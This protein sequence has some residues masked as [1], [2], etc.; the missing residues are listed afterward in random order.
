LNRKH[1]QLATAR[2]TAQALDTWQHWATGHNTT[3]ATLINTA[4]HLAARGGRHA[5]LAAPLT[6]WIHEHDIVPRPSITP[7]PA[8]EHHS[9]RRPSPSLGTEL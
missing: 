3:P 7:Q 9:P 4:H 2:R 6:T 8:P 1:E 5:A